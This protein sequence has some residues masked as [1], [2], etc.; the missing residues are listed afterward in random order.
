MTLLA[1]GL[2]LDRA[3]YFGFHTGRSSTT[4]QS[5]FTSVQ[6]AMPRTTN[7]FMMYEGIVEEVK[8]LIYGLL[9]FYP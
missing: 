4:N 2:L 6:V 1:G 3:V 9:P 8:K 7:L 5:F